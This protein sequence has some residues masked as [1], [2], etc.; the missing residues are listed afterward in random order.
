MFVR[1]Q[2][3]EP[4]QHVRR[5]GLDGE[6]LRE[7]LDRLA[8][9]SQIRLVA[10]RRADEQLEA[11]VVFPFPAQLDATA[12]QVHQARSVLLALVEL[13]ELVDGRRAGRIELEGALERC[14]RA[15]RIL[16]HVAASF[17]DPAPRGGTPLVVGDELRLPQEDAHERSPIAQER[18]QRVHLLERLQI[19]FIERKQTFPCI[20]GASRIVSASIVQ[21]RERRQELAL[22]PTVGP[23]NRRF[24]RRGKVVPAAG[25]R[26]DPVE[27]LA[28]IAVFGVERPRFPD[29]VECFAQVLAARFPER[30][31]LAPDRDAFAVV[32]RNGQA[33]LVERDQPPPIV[34]AFVDRAQ[35]VDGT[36]LELLR[37]QERLELADR[38]RAW[39][40]TL[41]SIEVDDRLQL[42]EP[43]G[44]FAQ[45]VNQQLRERR[46]EAR[47]VFRKCALLRP[48]AG[49]LGQIMPSRAALVESRQRV[50]DGRISIVDFERG[51]I[52]LDCRGVVVELRLLDARDRLEGEEPVL[53][54]VLVVERV[55]IELDAF[56]GAIGIPQQ[57]VDRREAGF[58]L[59]LESVRPPVEDE[60][61]IDVLLGLE[62]LA[63]APGE[64]RGRRFVGGDLF[65]LGGVGLR[66]APLRVRDAGE[67]L[68][69]RPG[70]LVGGL[71]A[72]QLRGRLERRT[73]VFLLLLV[74]LR[75]P[76][77]ELLAL[78]G[79]LAHRE[80]RLQ[81]RHDAAP[82]QPRHVDRL[83]HRR[84]AS[85]VLA[86][87]HEPLERGDCLGMLRIDRE[88][89]RVLVEG[90]LEFVRSILEHLPEGVVQRR[91]SFV[92][93]PRCA[94]LALVERDQVV[95]SAFT[96]VEAL[97]R[98]DRLDVEAHVENL[99]VDRDRR[100][101]VSH[102]FVAEARLLE[103]QGAT[104]RVALRQI[105]APLDD[106]EKSRMLAR[107]L[108]QRFERDESSPLVALQLESVGVVLLG[109]RRVREALSRKLG[110]PESHLE[111][112]VPVGD[113]VHGGTKKLDE[114][115]VLV[116][117]RREPL[118]PG[119]P[120]RQLRLGDGF[121]Q[122]AS[123][124]GKCPRGRSERTIGDVDAPR[125]G[126]QPLGG[127]IGVLRLDLEDAKEAVMQAVRFVKRSKDRGDFL[128]SGGL[129]EQRLERAPRAGIGR[130]DDESAA[131]RVDRRGDVVELRLPDVSQPREKSKLVRRRIGERHVA[132]ERFGELPPAARALVQRCESRE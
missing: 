94:Y 68:E 17:S 20:E 69:L 104:S 115:R 67:A 129:V 64:L 103:E 81:R 121:A 55:A 76:P 120:R 5:A 14:D 60:G 70:R 102:L 8:P 71:L 22:R 38:F 45:L 7:T 85:G 36:R 75:Q 126:G 92:G 30:R 4:A 80:A 119:N 84:R 72:E 105:R 24:V 49:E 61:S 10:R 114:L 9:T 83:E 113:L 65:E 6:G 18:G 48:P 88:C 11:Q 21:L 44:G 100:V 97:Q 40:P 51:A 86:L 27:V 87:G 43:R 19:R 63:G 82:V 34:R 53:R 89:G 91:L 118:D 50:E 31:V 33:L 66:E 124:V 13:D 47:L 117:D 23:G 95:P 46:A 125:D 25:R 1:V 78:V 90:T 93:Y 123:R 99:L 122:S 106:L 41:G 58:V 131:V 111:L 29:G 77:Q 132:L 107:L 127:R 35:D 110:D 28:R 74:E 2:R 26:A 79:L 101:G 15:V 54:I 52:R 37:L 32:R 73:V 56:R 57:A 108:V 128:L 109:E 96:R 42:V 98:G 112:Q 62:E 12:V 3:V 16:E 130:I 59:G 116:R 39:A